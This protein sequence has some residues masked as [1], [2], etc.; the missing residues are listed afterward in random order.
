GVVV[1]TVEFVVIHVLG[2]I[3]RPDNRAEIEFVVVVKPGRLTERVAIGH[4]NAQFAI[5]AVPGGLGLVRKRIGNPSQIT[6]LIIGKVGGGGFGAAVGSSGR[7]FAEVL[8]VMVGSNY[9]GGVSNEPD[10]IAC[11]REVRV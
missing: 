5:A 6:H 4:G 2:R 3:I 8:I 10:R 11:L 9:A 7:S 1:H